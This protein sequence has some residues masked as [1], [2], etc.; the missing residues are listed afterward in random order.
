M[1]GFKEPP[2]KAGLFKAKNISDAIRD[3][4]VKGLESGFYD[5]VLLP[6]RVPAG[7]SFAWILTDK[8]DVARNA[9]II[10]PIMPVQGGRTLSSVTKHGES[11]GRIL[12]IMR[13][14]EIRAGI[15]LFKLNQLASENILTMSYDCP[16]AMP[17][18]KYLKDPTKG[19]EA[20]ARASAKKDN[21]PMKPVCQNC[22]AFSLTSPD[23][24]IASEGLTDP[25]IVPVSEKGEKLLGKFGIEMTE[26]TSRWA[27]TIAKKVDKNESER[28]RRNLEL[29]AQFGG[30]EGIARA[31]DKCIECHNCM[32]VCPVCYC[33]RCY[34]ESEST[35]L[36]SEQ[37]LR[38]SQK[39]GAMRFSPDTLI[40]QIGRMSHMTTSCVSCGMCEDACPVGI[41]VAQLF[42]LIADETQ[43][44]FD[45]VAGRN[46][47]E[48]LPF[49]LFI[50]EKELPEIEAIC[51]DPLEEAK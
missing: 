25:L 7:D 3:F 50:A 15:E 39:K 47:D 18:E 1:R 21:A 19:D 38:R 49:R 20:F 46:R 4:A 9:T 22:I 28:K 17:V 34:F 37:F 24:H 42:S 13:P 32:R 26:E 14:C 51:A 45:Y 36:R 44:A 30:M 23:I 43:P 5:A 11:F 35:I 8:P 48:E 40:F 27:K 12:A 41:P 10:T 33:R 31:F 16:G 2:A 6:I 29:K